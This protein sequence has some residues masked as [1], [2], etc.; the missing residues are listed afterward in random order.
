M[1]KVVR[2]F[3]KE[4]IVGKLRDKKIKFKIFYT[5]IYQKRALRKL[6]NIF[7]CIKFNFV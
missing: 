2:K 7:F 4:K 6:I 3:S 5:E 1:L